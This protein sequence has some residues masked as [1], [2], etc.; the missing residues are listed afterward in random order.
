MI[1]KFEKLP[2]GIIESQTIDNIFVSLESQQFLTSSSFPQLAGSIVTSCNEH[3]STFV[4]STI[5]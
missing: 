4:E 5:G 2:I 3:I 1:N